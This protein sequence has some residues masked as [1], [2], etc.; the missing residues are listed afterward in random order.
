MV[1]AFLNT[2]KNFIEIKIGDS[3]KNFYIENKTTIE[4]NYSCTFY[5]QKSV[6]R[7]DE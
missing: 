6:K 1:K 4:N 2:F 5:F 3:Y 7:L